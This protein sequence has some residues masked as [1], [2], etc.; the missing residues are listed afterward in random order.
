MSGDE[1]KVFIGSAPTIVNVV[2]LPFQ[3]T[4]DSAEPTKPMSANGY[5]S[6]ITLPMY[7]TLHFAVLSV[8]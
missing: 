1:E 7:E 6:T 4:G 8:I 2:L 5:L 3:W